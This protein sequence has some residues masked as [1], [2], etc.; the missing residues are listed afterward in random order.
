M[1]LEALR[2][3]RFK[4]QNRMDEKEAFQSASKWRKQPT[5][6]GLY[7]LCFGM[8]NLLEKRWKI[9]QFQLTAF[10]NFDGINPNEGESTDF[11]Q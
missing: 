7:F 1:F 9:K 2:E 11:S 3:M 5:G 4:N 8:K 10:Y 6:L